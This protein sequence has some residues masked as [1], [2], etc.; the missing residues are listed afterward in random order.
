MSASR[1]ESSFGGKQRYFQ[2]SYSYGTSRASWNM[3]REAS[4]INNPSQRLYIH[5]I[6]VKENRPNSILLCRLRAV[7]TSFSIFLS[8]FVSYTIARAVILDR[9][10]FAPASASYF[11]RRGPRGSRPLPQREA[12]NKRCCLRAFSGGGGGGE[13]TLRVKVALS[14]PPNS[15]HPP[16]TF[17]CFY[18]PRLST[19]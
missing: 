7:D 5:R 8:S 19:C 6:N 14:L 4:Q 17:F 16:S 11:S 13:R 1:Q 2:K 15:G 3:E 12:I 18:C 10:A 9:V